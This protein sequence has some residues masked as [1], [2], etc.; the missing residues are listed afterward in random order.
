MNTGAKIPFQSH[1]FISFGFMDRSRIAGSYQLQLWFW[2][3]EEHPHYFPQRLHKFIFPPIVQK[4][5]FVHSSPLVF[6]L[7]AIQKGVRWYLSRV[8]VCVF[9]MISY[10]EQ[11]FMYLLAT[12]MPPLEKY[13]LSSSAHVFTRVFVFLLLSY[14]RFLFCY[15]SYIRFYLFWICIYIQPI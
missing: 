8:V 10:A 13:L 6:L 14:I 3:F 11:F 2:F 15:F 5:S 4:F 12:C 7:T 9:L 1:E